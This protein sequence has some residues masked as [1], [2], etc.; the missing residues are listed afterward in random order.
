M[1]LFDVQL[2]ICRSRMSIPECE[3]P[4]KIPCLLIVTCQLA[5][6]VLAVIQREI[7]VLEM[8]PLIRSTLHLIW[9]VL[10]R[11]PFELCPSLRHIRKGDLI[12]PEKRTR[13][14]DWE[15]GSFLR[16][17]KLYIFWGHFIETIDIDRVTHVNLPLQIFEDLE[18]LWQS[19]SEKSLTIFTDR[20]KES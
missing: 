11:W 15:C 3:A 10:M 14:T 5:Q 2:T 1:R 17:A 13:V 16:S 19:W 20:G 8:Q 6:Q 4:P 9:T 18:D 7:C 12:Q